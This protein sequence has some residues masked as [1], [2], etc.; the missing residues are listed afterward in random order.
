YTTLFRSG[1]LHVVGVAA[2]GDISPPRVGRSRMRAAE[3][4]QAGDMRIADAGGLQRARESVAVELRVVA[5]TRHGTHVYQARHR[6]CLEQFD[7]LLQRTRGV[8]HGQYGHKE[9]LTIASLICSIAR[10]G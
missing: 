8:P 9:S 5:G 4:P 10:D 2:E 3:A 1:R 7:E 6:V